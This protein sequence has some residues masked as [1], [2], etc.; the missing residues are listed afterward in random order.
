MFV[1]FLTQKAEWLDVVLPLC[2]EVKHFPSPSSQGCFHKTKQVII[3]LFSSTQSFD[4]VPF[5]KLVME[6]WRGGK[7]MQ[8]ENGTQKIH[9]ISSIFFVSLFFFLKNVIMFGYLHKSVWS[10]FD[11]QAGEAGRASR[12][13]LGLIE[14]LPTHPWSAGCDHGNH[15][16]SHDQQ[17]SKSLL[18]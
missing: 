7:S 2:H 5:P 16:R 14:L 11:W 10:I 6:I 15:T 17:T 8:D 1:F 12:P 4:F 13:L 18:N 9:H 3:F